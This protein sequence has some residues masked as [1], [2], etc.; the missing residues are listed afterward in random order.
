MT[1]QAG[2][3]RFT[4]SAKRTWRPNGYESSPEVF[5]PT[6]DAFVSETVRNRPA[7]ALDLG[8]GPGFTTRL[9]SRTARPERT[10][11]MDRSKAFLSQA[12]SSAGAGEEY[13]AADVA[14]GPLR[15]AGIGAQPDLI[16]ARFLSSHLPE[17]EQA[18]AGWALASYLS[19]S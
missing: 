16:Y 11:G 1:K 8:C 3:A 12:R 13:L 4:P 15:I 14:V 9:L 17:P 10:V 6:S 18:V 5:D 7:L 2:Q 19:I